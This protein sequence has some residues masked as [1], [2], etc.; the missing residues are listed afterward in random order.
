[1]FDNLPKN[2]MPS[3]VSI[4]QLAAAYSEHKEEFAI[5]H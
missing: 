5:K 4:S 1:V 2:E 3:P